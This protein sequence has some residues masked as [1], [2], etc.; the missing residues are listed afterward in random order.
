[1]GNAAPLP[2]TNVVATT[3][4][5]KDTLSTYKSLIHEDGSNEATKWRE[6]Q[7]V[8]E[9]MDVDVTEGDEEDDFGPGCYRFSFE[10]PGLGIRHGDFWIRQEYLNMY[11]FCENYEKYTRETGPKAPSVVITGQP[12]KTYWVLYALRRR[13]AERKPVIWYRELNLYLF[14]ADGVYMA[15]QYFRPST[16]QA[17]VW[18]LIDTDEVDGVP[19]L[20]VGSDTQ[21]FIIFSSSPKPSRWSNMRKTTQCVICIMNPW[22]KKEI[23]KAA[24]IHGLAPNDERMYDMYDQFGPT[25]RICFEYT[26]NEFLRHE[27]ITCYNTALNN[28]SSATL[29][30]LVNKLKVHSMDAVSPMLLLV[31]RMSKEITKAGGTFGDHDSAM[32]VSARV[33]LVSP[34]AEMDIRLKLWEASRIEQLELYRPLVNVPA[35]RSIAGLAFEALALSKMQKEII[36]NLFPMV[37]G[38][39]NSSRWHSNHGAGGSPSNVRL[40]LY[41]K[42][43]PKW[44]YLYEGSSLEKVEDKLYYMPKSKTKV[45]FDS[46]IMADGHLY[47]FQCTVA[48]DHSINAGIVNFFTQDSLPPKTR[49]HFVFVDS[50][51]RELLGTM[52]LFTAPLDVA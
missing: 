22:T 16:F 14:V 50:R 29:R 33:E 1:M 18:T 7:P 5:E 4:M 37:K 34:V 8:D 17:L 47:I 3:T 9:S 25:A 19:P 38:A 44:S 28:L 48:P 41:I 36:L 40:P 39:S 13:L 24:V 51:L 6:T 15:P 2:L 32:A 31:K 49:W 43:K 21:L 10:T 46:F 11:D 20:L 27:H 42:I 12:G 26:K 45:A 30:S 23:A 52:K 35:T